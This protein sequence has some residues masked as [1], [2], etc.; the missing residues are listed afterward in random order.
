M[1]NTFPHFAPLVNF[2]PRFFPKNLFTAY[3]QTAEGKKRGESREAQ[4]LE[5]RFS[6]SPHGNGR[7]ELQSSEIAFQLLSSRLRGRALKVLPG[8]GREISVEKS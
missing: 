6:V 4:K 7:S 3:S 1:A 5:K 8:A 2:F